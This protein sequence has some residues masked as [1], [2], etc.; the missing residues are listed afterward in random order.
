MGSE[1]KCN[2]RAIVVSSPLSIFSRTLRHEDPFIKPCPSIE[3]QGNHYHFTFFVRSRGR[4]W[5]GARHAV[6]YVRQPKKT[7]RVNLDWHRLILSSCSIYKKNHRPLIAVLKWLNLK[8]RQCFNLPSCLFFP[9][10]VSSDCSDLK[11]ARWVKERRGNGKNGRKISEW[12][13]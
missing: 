1:N 6:G 10:I 12:R 8:W 3:I 7:G 13:G 5:N 2:V 4:W 11:N 9:C